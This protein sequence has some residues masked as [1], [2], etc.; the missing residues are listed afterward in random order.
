MIVEDAVG[1]SDREAHEKALW[2]MKKM[3]NTMTT[4]EVVARF[5]Q[6]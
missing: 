6:R 5:K 1:S 2:V 4:E 3:F